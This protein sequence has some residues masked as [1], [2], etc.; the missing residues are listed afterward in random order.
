LLFFPRRW[1]TALTLASVTPWLA[2]AASLVTLIGGCG[3]SPERSTATNRDH[4]VGWYKRSGGDTVIPVFMRDGTY[5]SVCRGVEVPLRPCPE[6]LEWAVTPSSMTGTKIGWDATSKTYYL[7]VMD[8]QA[9]NFTDGRSGV[10]E[11]EPMTRIEKPPELL[12]AKARRPRTP[13]DLLGWYQPVWFPW[14][15]IEIRKDGERYLSQD[16]EFRGATPGS[17]TTRLETRELTP[18]PDQ[19]GFTGFER[20]GGRRLVYHAPL[21]RFELVM[22]DTKRTPAVI[23]MPLARVGAP[24][25]PES[26]GAPQPRVMIGIPSWH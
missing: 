4:L 6:G 12:D 7:A 17:W 14:V 15:R 2:L 9:S 23:R 19:L 25:S 22:M 13:D 10:G 26:D 21:K 20:H 5:Y 24:S 16:H 1:A 3:K 11:K 18:L 8:G